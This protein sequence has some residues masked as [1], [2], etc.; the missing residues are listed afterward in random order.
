MLGWRKQV[1]KK[2]EVPFLRG[3]GKGRRDI[4]MCWVYRVISLDA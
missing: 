3:G 4:K 1:L 2:G